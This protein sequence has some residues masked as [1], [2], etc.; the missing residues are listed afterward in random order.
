MSICI[1]ETQYDLIGVIYN[2]VAHFV[3]YVRFPE[4]NNVKEGTYFYDDIVKKA[5]Q[6]NHFGFIS[7]S[8]IPSSMILEICERKIVK[9]SAL[10]E[11]TIALQAQDLT[12]ADATQY[13]S[14][15]LL[16]FPR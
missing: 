13:F 15:T 1:E 8:S 11:V 16:M 14:E 7:Y 9:L 2:V 6:V 12:L 4:L 5:V 10:N 3:A